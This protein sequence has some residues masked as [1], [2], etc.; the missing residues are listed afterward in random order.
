M[1]DETLSRRTAVEV[2]F[3]GV[4]VTKSIRPYL[5]GLTYT[6]NEEDEADDLQLRLQDRNRLWR[7][8]WITPLL[9]A[10]GGES[11]RIGAV[12]LQQNPRGGGKDRL[13]DCG[14]FELDTVKSGGPP[15][16]VTLKATG[17]PFGGQIRQTKASRAWENYSLSGIA[18]EIAAR[19]GLS[20]M[21]ECAAD[22]S[23]SRVEQFQESGIAFL[24][25]LCKNA[26]I[27][28]KATGSLL[29]LFDQARYEAKPPVREIKPGSGYISYDIS[30]G[31]AGGGYASCRVL[32]TDPATGRTIEGAATDPD[33]K[34]GQRLDVTAR[35][36]SVGEA[37]ALAEK[38]LRLHNKFGQ[39]A[40]FTFPGDPGLVAG[41]T[42]ELAGWG[43]GDGKYI[44]KKAAHTVGGG[45]YTTKIT[46]RKVLEGY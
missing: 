17:L 37:R 3:G 46:L 42:V 30:T 43:F 15:A 31:R 16:V 13:L 26:G 21:F 36:G 7:E 9:R 8:K 27:S 44:I 1:S 14:S 34:S 32:Y 29:V 41:I 39:T 10:A 4:N 18:K 12:I 38:Q 28:L 23:Y 5:L 25:R 20:C 24:S 40:G 33:N 45:G 11:L 2:S 35:V 19:N 22:P 6:D